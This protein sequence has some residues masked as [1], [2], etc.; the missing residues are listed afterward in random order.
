MI[1][2]WVDT[3]A[4]Q[5]QQLIDLSR[6]AREKGV[7]VVVHPQVHLEKCR[8]LRVQFGARF[9]SALIT[10]A[11]EQQGVQIA[12]MAFDQTRAERWADQLA[13][14]F[15]TPEAWQEAKRK[16]VKAKLPDDTALPKRVPMTTDWLI[17]LDV[18]ERTEDFIVVNDRGPEW[19]ALREAQPPRAFDYDA[20]LA[21][22]RACPDR[23]PVEWAT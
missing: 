10:Q 14:R 1:R 21:W 12:A 19:E 20:A 22:L 4:I 9:S 13:A 15:P 2:L 3:S 18:A 6:L 16:S 5:G 8:Q 23:P 7:A 11:L 17:A